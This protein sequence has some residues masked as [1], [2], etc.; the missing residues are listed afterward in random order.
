MFKYVS[1][2]S[3]YTSLL[4]YVCMYSSLSSCQS[5]S[6]D[7]S[8]PSHS[9]NKSDSHINPAHSIIPKPYDPDMAEPER[10]T[11]LPSVFRT[12]PHHSRMTREQRLTASG[13]R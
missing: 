13:G 6:S 5:E 11:A 10:H 7:T 9:R 1:L 3:V 8:L 4:M 2:M 12:P